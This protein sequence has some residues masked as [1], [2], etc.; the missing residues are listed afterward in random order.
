MNLTYYLEITTNIGCPNI[1]A[2]Y[3]PQEVLIKNYGNQNRMMTFED[4]EK[5]LSHVPNHV[6][7]IFSGFSEPF[8]NKRCTD[9][10]KLAYQKG[11]KIHVFTTLYGVSE[12]DVKELSKMKASILVHLPDSYGILKEPPTQGY[13]DRFFE[14]QESIA[15]VRTMSMNDAFETCN[16]E[17]VAR[18]KVKPRRYGKCHNFVRQIMPV[19]LPNGNTYLCCMDFGLHDY[20]GNLLNESYDTIVERILQNEGKF[21]NCNYCERNVPLLRYIMYECK[22][23]ADEK[24]FKEKKE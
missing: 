5:I 12:N 9:M 23:I 15:D 7:I 16:R 6:A 17:N 8:A 10:I 11:H 20:V 18:N 13:R 1:C 14:I 4:F 2:K 19:V 3:C 22:V 21:Y 24:I